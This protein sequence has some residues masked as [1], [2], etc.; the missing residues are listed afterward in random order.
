MFINKKIRTKGGGL[1]RV[2][3]H[4]VLSYPESHSLGP[5][6]LHYHRRNDG[7]DGSRSSSSS[8]V[9]SSSSSS[10]TTNCRPSLWPD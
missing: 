9:L 4:E 7:G 10:L 2:W 8:S 5:K 6:T 1:L 3:R